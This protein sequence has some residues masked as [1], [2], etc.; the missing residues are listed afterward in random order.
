MPPSIP[1]RIFG[2]LPTA[3]SET[4]T[5]SVKRETISQAWGTKPSES[6]PAAGAQ[7]DTATSEYGGMAL[8]RTTSE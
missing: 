4:L 5:G 8:A 6:S 3:E 2:D 1:P 7:L